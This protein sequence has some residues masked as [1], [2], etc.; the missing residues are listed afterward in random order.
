MAHN[1]THGTDIK[2][3]VILMCSSDNQYQEFEVIDD[4]FDHYSN[5]WLDRIETYYKIH[6]K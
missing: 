5:R 6:N 1:A 3:G 4:E 2:T